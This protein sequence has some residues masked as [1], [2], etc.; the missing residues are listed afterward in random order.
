VGVF[1]EILWVLKAGISTILAAI[2]WGV[3]LG[4]KYLLWVLCGDILL[5]V[6]A[7]FTP[8]IS[9]IGATI[10]SL[11]MVSQTK[12]SQAIG[13]HEIPR[14]WELPRIVSLSQN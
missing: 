12:A 4:S 6:K 13:C 14:F 8:H 9:P 1:G 2:R 5:G 11:K 10:N 7:A 3:Y